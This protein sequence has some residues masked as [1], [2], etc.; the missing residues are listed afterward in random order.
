[1]EAEKSTLRIELSKLFL[2]L[3]GNING[4]SEFKPPPAKV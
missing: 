1:M 3:Y 4:S 2:F